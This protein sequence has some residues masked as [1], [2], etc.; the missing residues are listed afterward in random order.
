MASGTAASSSQRAK[1]GTAAAMTYSPGQRATEIVYGAAHGRLHNEP[2]KPFGARNL[3][4]KPLRLPLRQIDRQNASLFINDYKLVAGLLDSNYAL[5][6]SR[7][8]HKSSL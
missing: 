7:A 4:I 1:S 8:D 5:S 2:E 6:I 3:P